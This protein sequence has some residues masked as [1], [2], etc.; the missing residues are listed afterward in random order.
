[1]KKIF[2]LIDGLES[3]LADGIDEL[4]NDSGREF[5]SEKGKCDISNDQPKNILIPEVNIHAIEDG[6]EKSR[7]K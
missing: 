5:I 7:G 6:G 3:E 4:M 1:M 2:A